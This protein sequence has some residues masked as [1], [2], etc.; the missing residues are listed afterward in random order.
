MSLF[1]GNLTIPPA[2]N[3]NAA[4]GR[5]AARQ[6]AVAGSRSVVPLVYG[7]DRIGALVLNVLPAGSASATLLVQ[8]LWGFGGEGVLDV[9]LN[10]QA[11]PAGSTTTHYTGSQSTADSAL[12]AAFSAQGI[13]YTDT[14]AGYTYSV[15]ALP[16]RAIEGSLN[17]SARVR[18]R[19]LYDPR[20][21]STVA[22][23]S[24]PHRSNNPGTWEW[25]DN[26]ALA[27]GDFLA[28]TSYGCGLVV[29][30]VALAASANHCDALIGTPAEKRR[31][32]GVSFLQSLPV[33]QIADA[34][35][36]Y[37]GCWLVPG[38][39]GVRLV[40][41]A[42]AAAAASFA[43]AS[44]QI[45]SLS[46]L[47]LR[48]FGDLPTVVEVLYTDTRTIPWREGSASA[49]VT[50]AGST[51]PWRLS[52]VRLPGVQRYSQALREA[53][54]RLNKLNLQQ[55]TT[56]LDVFDHGIAIEEGDIVEIT[57]PVGVTAKP[58]RVTAAS[59]TGPGR[60][61]LQLVEHSAS[62]YSTSVVSPPTLQQP[63]FYNPAGAPAA[64]AG[65]AG[66]VAKGTITWTWTAP[67]E[68]DA[69]T[70]LRVGGTDWAS[71][72]PL[73][74]GRGTS[75]VQRV[76]SAATYTVRARHAVPDGT[77]GWVESASTTSASAVV[78]AGDL[79]TVDGLGVQTF[80]VVAV[81]YSATSQPTSSS[82]AVNGTVHTGAARSYT[83]HR[84]R[85]SDGVVEFTQTYDVFGS[86]EQTSGRDA[87]AL[88]ADL[89]ATT[90]AYVVVV[91]SHDEPASYRLTS[92]LPAAMYR[93]G[94][95]RAVFGSPQFK[96]RSA[97]VL[98]GI[99]GCGEGNGAEMYQGEINDDPN[100]WV[101]V[102]FQVYAGQLLGVSASFTPRTLADY[103][104]TGSLSAVTTFVSAT[105]PTATAVGDIWV[106]SANGN[107]ISRWN[108]SA[109]AQVPLGTDGLASDAATEMLE[110]FDA[111]GIVYS[112]MA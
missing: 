105:A 109:W 1:W 19:R 17:I 79:L 24:G 53:T 76:T 87:A 22:G 89:N 59:L 98:I 88:A 33:A 107:R 58:M 21:D 93:C 96:I 103:A 104:Y 4:A 2:A 25:S 31:I 106:D 42:N 75:L 13:T 34:L 46:A 110:F 37:A 84:I 48:D 112:N 100:A 81:G 68:T 41:D 97:Y 101:D 91:R 32:V 70:R 39:N 51:R 3:V 8:C 86:G 66:T 54:E 95:S 12:V 78:A 29:E 111:V 45:L 20:K 99:A 69:E 9:R 43:H 73:W 60:W 18:G 92:G 94:A 90:S 47:R 52:Q 108:G 28:S 102:A 67:T 63:P 26:P 77:G 74:S 7:E 38:V 11:L 35:R 83:M 14:L 36:A 55:L 62:V 44:G 82:L 15:V 16:A 6:L 49:Q 27:L 80:R 65:L 85:R 72:T 64:V 40:P 23:G 30:P 57:H 71:A 5:T 50:G 10:D 61:R 56:E